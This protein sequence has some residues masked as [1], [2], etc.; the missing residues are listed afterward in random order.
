VKLIAQIPEDL[1]ALIKAE[2][3]REERSITSVVRRALRAHFA[4]KA[5]EEAA[6]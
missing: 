2:A 3:E 5:E 4:A 1:H 6:A